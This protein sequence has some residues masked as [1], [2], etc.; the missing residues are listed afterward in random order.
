MARSALWR[1]HPRRALGGGGASESSDL[2]EA[3]SIIAATDEVPFLR[4]ERT[5]AVA[6]ISRA[7]RSLQA[8]VAMEHKALCL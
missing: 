5:L 4:G 1:A 7:L 3:S 8:E 6:A 2:K